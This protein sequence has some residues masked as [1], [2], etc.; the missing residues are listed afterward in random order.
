[1]SEERWIGIGLL[2]LLAFA[3]SSLV[4]FIYFYRNSTDGEDI[5]FPWWMV[6]ILTA[7]ACLLAMLGYSGLRMILG[8]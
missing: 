2:C 4:A 6:I 7:V 1:M 5:G 3:A 8:R